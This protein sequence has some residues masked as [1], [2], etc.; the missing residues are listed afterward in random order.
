MLYNLLKTTGVP[1]QPKGKFDIYIS[2]GFNINAAH[3]SIHQSSNCSSWSSLGNLKTPISLNSKCFDRELKDTHMIQGEYANSNSTTRSEKLDSNFQ[4]WRWEVS[5]LSTELSIH[6]CFVYS[7]Y[8]YTLQS[9]E[10]YRD[11]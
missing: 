11:V 10:V 9:K 1:Q 4:P 7:G 8:I 5:V 3:I 2:R 6:N